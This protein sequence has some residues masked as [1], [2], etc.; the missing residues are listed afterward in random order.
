MKGPLQGFK[1]LEMAGI[2]PG[3]FCAMML[4][5]M[6]AEVIRVDRLHPGFLGGGG[7]TID[8]GRRS[9]ALD[10]KKPGA[11]DIILRL[12]KT[13]DALI[14]G[15]RPGVMERLGLGPDVC[16]QHNPRLV[17][18]RMTGWGQTGPLAQAA[19]HD[20]NYLSITG[21]LNAMGY[22][23]RPPTPPL[24]LVGDLG[25]G[26][27][28]LAYGIVC[29]LLEASRSGKGQVIDAAVCDGVA[30]LASAYFGM[31]AQRKWTTQREANTLDGGAPFYGCYACSDGRFVSIGPIEP[32]FYE[33]LLALCKIEDP[34]F[35]DQWD[36]QQWPIMKEAMTKIFASRT[37]DEWCELLEG[38]DACFAPV[39]DFDE[40]LTYPHNI[41]RQSFVTTDGLTHPAPSP[42]LSR[43]P[44]SAGSIPKT[45]GDTFS[46]LQEHGYT[47]EDIARLCEAGTIGP[48]NGQPEHHFNK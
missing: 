26:G 23:D 32:Q 38:T 31:V 37:R 11:I 36:K 9:I 3:H 5:D 28:M 14:E 21:A 6:G 35:K 29:A 42:R 8:R 15:F 20:V 17:Y 33:R 46:L 13:A 47:R 19:G 12:M 39:L 44:A 10:V 34:A 41:A 45:G 24:H 30:T 25:G 16:L 1:V 4:A 48:L 18:G 22:A 43:T 40:A 7:T 27:M 2:G